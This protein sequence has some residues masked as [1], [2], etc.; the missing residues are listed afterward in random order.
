MDAIAL[1]R[2][3][4]AEV[5]SLFSEFKK[6]EEPAKRQQL[7]EEI[8]DN[9]AAHCEIEEKLFYP[10]VFTGDLEEVVKEAAE[11]HLSAKRVIADLLEME[12]TDSQYEAKM[13]VLNELINHHVKEE[14]AELFPAAREAVE[15]KELKVLG[16]KMEEMFE[17]LIPTSPRNLVP[18]QTTS[19]APLPLNGGADQHVA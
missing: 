9:L 14:H 12:P 7:F 4:H 15:S 13:S 1:L 18:K 3:Q 11:E 17:R 6:T 2:K 16:E 10:A 5:K 8:A 19:A